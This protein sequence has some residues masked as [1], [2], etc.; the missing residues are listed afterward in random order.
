MGHKRNGWCI[1]HMRQYEKSHHVV[2]AHI[3]S[4]DL[5]RF[6]FVVSLESSR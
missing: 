4:F 6:F 3:A 5:K 2:E 1:H